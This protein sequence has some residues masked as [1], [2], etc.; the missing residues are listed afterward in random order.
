MPDDQYRIRASLY[1]IEYA[2]IGDHAFLQSFLTPETVSVME[3][4]SGSGRNVAW[5][6][7]SGR[8]VTFIDR[9]PAMIQ[10]VAAKIEAYGACDRMT[11]IVDDM[12]T[13]ALNRAF[14]LILVPQDAFLLVAKD[15]VLTVL[16]TLRNHLATEGKL[17]LDI[18]LFGGDLR[19]R[20]TLPAFYDPAIQDGELI[21]EWKRQ[22]DSNHYLVRK[23][24]Q[25][26]TF[27]TIRIVFKYQIITD[28]QET[29]SYSS[30]I[31]LARYD[32]ASIVTLVSA[33]GLHVQAAFRNYTREEYASDANR[34]LLV[35]THT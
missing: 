17:M 30:D 8:A 27:D 10:R 12:R 3:I 32:Y 7:K 13:L 22:I 15:D 18:G 35:L 21:H 24:R 20:E 26:H 14:D 28:D 33:A 11:A 2:F 31:E 23:R 6:A 1:D 5:L 19:N 9:E 16:W 29:N 4:P 25:Y 34:V